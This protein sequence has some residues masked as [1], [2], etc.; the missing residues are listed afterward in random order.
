M[1]PRTFFLV[2]DNHTLPGIQYLNIRVKSL[3]TPYVS[4]LYDYQPLPCLPNNN[5]IAQAVDYAVRSLGI[6]R[7]SI[8]YCLMLQNVV[9]AD[10]QM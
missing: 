10:L 5:S 6:N 3:K 9:A 2:I 1:L 8:F 4:Y 7:N